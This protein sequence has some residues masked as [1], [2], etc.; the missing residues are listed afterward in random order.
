MKTFWLNVGVVLIALGV[1][2]VALSRSIETGR[3][4][5]REFDDI[6]NVFKE[7]FETYGYRG[8]K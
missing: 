2:A 6:E 3:T 8:W 5:K 4:W 7:I 1:G